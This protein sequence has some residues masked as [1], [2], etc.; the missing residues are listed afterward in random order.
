M[1][2]RRKPCPH[3]NLVCELCVTQYS[4]AAKRF[5]DGIN[6]LLT[7]A[8][9]YELR[10]KFLAISLRDG[11]VSSEIFDTREDAVRNYPDFHFLMP[12][13][14]FLQGLK[15]LDAEM[16][17]MFQRDAHDSGMRVSDG[18]DAILPIEAGDKYRELLLKGLRRN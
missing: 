2:A 5:S 16:I 4:D 14:N 13:G 10:N 15:P 3:G 18:K 1:A 6:A 8:K 7:Y 17:L 9:P 11:S 12:V